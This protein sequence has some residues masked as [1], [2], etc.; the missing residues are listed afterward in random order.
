[1][2]LLVLANTVSCRKPPFRIIL[3]FSDIIIVTSRMNAD[4]SFISLVPFTS[5]SISHSVL[6]HTLVIKAH[7]W[8]FIRKLIKRKYGLETEQQKEIKRNECVESGA[9]KFMALPPPWT[10]VYAMMNFAIFM[11]F[12][13]RWIIELEFRGS[14]IPFYS[15]SAKALVNFNY[16]VPNAF[17]CRRVATVFH[18]KLSW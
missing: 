7:V 1:M 4:K 3:P 15:M 12:F 9:L 11:L 18:S 10:F 13:L 2:T 8:W 5:H 6:A 16:G 17:Q 14:L